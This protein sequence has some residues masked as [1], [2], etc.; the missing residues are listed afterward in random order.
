MLLYASVGGTLRVNNEDE[1]RALIK[2][3]C[4]NEYH[5]NDRV[6]KQKVV[7]VVNSDATPLAQMEVLSK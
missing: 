4:Q 7:L 5:S 2:N 6:V 3:M 1:V